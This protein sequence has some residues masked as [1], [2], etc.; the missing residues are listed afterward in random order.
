MFFKILKEG[1][2]LGTRKI[3]IHRKVEYEFEEIKN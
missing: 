2:I 1:K 3:N